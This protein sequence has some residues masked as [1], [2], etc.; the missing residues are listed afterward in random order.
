MTACKCNPLKCFRDDKESN[1]TKKTE[2]Y[3]IIHTYDYS[4][5]HFL[6]WLDKTS[7][8]KKG[9]KTTQHLPHPA[10]NLSNDNATS[11][12]SKAELIK[13]SDSDEDVV[14]LIKDD[15]EELGVYS[16]LF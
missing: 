10:P 9:M 8:Q 5:Q 15:E 1:V 7:K 3:V 13:V 6:Q 12:K 4:V 2:V 16:S 11:Q 14:E